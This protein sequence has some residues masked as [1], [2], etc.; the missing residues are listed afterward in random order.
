MKTLSVSELCD[1]LSANGWEL[2][3]NKKPPVYHL[4]RAVLPELKV[5]VT[6]GMVRVHEKQGQYFVL[7]GTAKSAQQMVATDNVIIGAFVLEKKS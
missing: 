6:G 1:W 2:K 4:Y 5:M 7:V 3:S